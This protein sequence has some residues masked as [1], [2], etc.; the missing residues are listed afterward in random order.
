MA[1]VFVVAVVLLLVALLVL[2]GRA[3]RRSRQRGHLVRGSTD[4]TV[5]IRE[6]QRDGKVINSLP[7]A[8]QRDIR[9]TALGRRNAARPPFDAAP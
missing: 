9:W 3:D 1:L 4:M 2:L 7:G 6:A 5:D 8:A